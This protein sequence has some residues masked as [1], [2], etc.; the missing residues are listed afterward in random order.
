[1]R[2][3]LS[4]VWKRVQDEMTVEKTFA[5]KNTNGILVPVKDI[6]IPDIFF[7]NPKDHQSAMGFSNHAQSFTTPYFLDVVSPYGFD[8]IYIFFIPTCNS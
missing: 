1:M 5:K 3:C 8:F 4:H 7:K 2:L 6:K